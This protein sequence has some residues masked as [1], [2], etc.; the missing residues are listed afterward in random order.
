MQLAEQNG[1]D[2]GWTYD[3]HVNWPEPYALLTLA[4]R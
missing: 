3:S 2:Y 4:A 1:F